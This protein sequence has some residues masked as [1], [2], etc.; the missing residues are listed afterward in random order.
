MYGPWI[1]APLPDTALPPPPLGGIAPGVTVEVARR[2]LS[3]A[4]RAAGLDTPGLDARV[5]V[6]HVL[7]LDQAGLMAAAGEKLSGRQAADVMVATRRRLAGEP[8]ARI[9]AAKEFWGLEFRLNAATL[10]PRPDT[11][12]IVEAALAALDSSA[13]RPRVGPERSPGDRQRPLK[14]ADLGTGSGALLLALLSELPNAFGIGTDID[15]S[16]LAAARD[17]AA[18]L[19]LAGR[20]TFAACDF[21]AALGEGFDLVV[22]NP[23][24]I[25]SGDIAHLDREVRDHDPRA[26]LDG[27]PDGLA[28]YR[29]IAGDAMRLLRCN[30]HLVVEIGVG[31]ANDVAPLFAAAGLPQHGIRADLA[32][33]TRALVFAWPYASCV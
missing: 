7:G 5:L 1:S 4:F 20:A 16:A 8:V 10:V 32:G 6:R 31:M 19:G 13:S 11:E 2:V 12:T 33:V 25:R 15:P 22:S 21:T 26:A 18:R 29:A 27:G 9:V 24:Y 3:R 14:I 23:P 17:N 30:G 28:C